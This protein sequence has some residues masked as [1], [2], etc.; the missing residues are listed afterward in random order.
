MTFA[1]V[2]SFPTIVTLAA[3]VGFFSSAAEYVF[4]QDVIVHAARGFD[5]KPEIVISLQANSPELCAQDLDKAIRKLHDN[6][7]N[8]IFSVDMNLIQN[9]AF[10]IMKYDYV[11]QHSISTRSGVFTT[12][13]IDV[14]HQED[15]DYLNANCQPCEHIG[16]EEK[17]E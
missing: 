10:R 15:V 6:D 12:G 2:V 7:R 14:H 5:T 4:K 11:F 3:V 17:V 8:E 16:E 9:A 1:A 13:Y